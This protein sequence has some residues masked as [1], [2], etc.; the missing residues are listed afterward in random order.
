MRRVVLLA[1]IWGWSF[2][3]I[4]VAVKGM[5]PFT[6][7]TARMGLGCCALV[8]LGRTGAA[9]P[10]L[11]LPREGAYWRRVAVAGIMGCAVPFSLLAWSEQRI[12]SA[13]ASVAQ[14]TTTM[15]TALFAA[16]LLR[17]RLRPLQAVGLVGGLVGVAVAAGLGA[18]DLRGASVAGVVAGVGAGA[19]YGYT[20]V[21][22]ERHLVAVAPMVAATGQL[23]VGTLALAPFALATTAMD[24]IQLTATR[25]VAL[26]LLGVMGTGV[27]YWLNFGAI[28]AVGATAASLVTYL[29]PPVAVVV[30]WLVLGEAVDLSL[31]IG[32]ALIVVSVAAVR[33]RPL[34]RRATA[35]HVEQLAS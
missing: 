5:T 31:V 34:G 8:V 4:K 18:G 12:T 24:G 33:Y 17:Q 9:G 27:A 1:T 11:R 6:L 25:I 2:L 23:L 29:V 14:G 35:A 28:A 19:S 10:R 13:L 26:V 16:L 15:F 3:F 32:L 30:G 7:A 21:H 22:N 20:F